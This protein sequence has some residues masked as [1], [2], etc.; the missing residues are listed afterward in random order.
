[1]GL[2][3]GVGRTASARMVL[4][5]TLGLLDGVSAF[6]KSFKG[7]IPQSPYIALTLARRRDDPPG[8]DFVHDGGLASVM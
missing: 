5:V 2:L 8:Q 3:R 7:D 4:I 1:M 6:R